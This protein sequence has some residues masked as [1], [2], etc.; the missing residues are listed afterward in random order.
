[1]A[2]YNCSNCKEQKADLT[3]QGHF[4]CRNCG[5]IYWT[6]FDRPKAGRKGQGIYCTECGNQNLQLVDKMDEVEVLRCSA[7]AFT[8]L[9]HA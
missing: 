2:L 1:M 9:R 7:C 6:I 3:E 4:K 5:A 8:L